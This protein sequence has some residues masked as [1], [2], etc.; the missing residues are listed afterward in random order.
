LPVRKAEAERSPEHASIV[1]NGPVAS[2][3]AGRMSSAGSASNAV[4]RARFADG[5]LESELPELRGGG[6]GRDKT[7][8]CG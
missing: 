3:E 5:G 7:Y 8:G 4:L 6:A 1:Q 2:I